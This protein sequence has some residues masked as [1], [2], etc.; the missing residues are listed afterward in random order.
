MLA[1]IEIV[2][3]H[4]ELPIHDGNGDAD[5][6]QS[7]RCKIRKRSRS[8][9]LKTAVVGPIARATTRIAVSEKAG[10]V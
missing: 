7:V 4:Q 1:Q 3:G 10:F 8:T 9:T 6:D 2:V 5:R